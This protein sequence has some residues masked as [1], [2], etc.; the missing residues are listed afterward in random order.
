MWLTDKDKLVTVGFTKT[1]E[2]EFSLWDPKNLAE[3]LGH[4]TLDSMSGMIMPFYDAENSILFLAGKGDGNIRYYEIT[5]EKPFFFYLS[6]FKSSASQRGCCLIPKR[7]VNTSICEIAR[8]L[9]IS[10]NKVE[11]V[12]FAVPRKVVLFCI[13]PF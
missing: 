4:Q 9:K 3:P 6:E 1:A 10:G 11:P 2:R 7:A 5:D 8:M 13:I 12:S